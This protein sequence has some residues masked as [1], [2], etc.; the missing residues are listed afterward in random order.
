MYQNPSAY[1]TVLRSN[2]Q[3]LQHIP[4]PTEEMQ[5]VGVAQDGLAI[6]YLPAPSEDVQKTAVC[7]NV[8]ALQYIPTPSED[9]LHLALTSQSHGLSYTQKTSWRYVMNRCR[10]PSDALILAAIAKWTYDDA[11]RGPEWLAAVRPDPSPEIDMAVAVAVGRFRPGASEA[12]TLA[13][14]RRDGMGLRDV[15]TQTPELVRAAVASDASALAHVSDALFSEDVVR[16]ALTAPM[17]S[18][19]SPVAIAASRGVPVTPELQ[20]LW[21]TTS[22]RNIRDFPDADDDLQ[23]FSMDLDSSAYMSIRG[24]CAR[25]TARDEEGYSDY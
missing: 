23:L 18:D 19:A 7:S 5:R 11:V 21:V 10:A 1:F 3:V 4:D 9:V 15:E 16:L 14:L 25:A 12:V 20:R 13:A 17:Y 22:P 8:K 24:P 2:G 6:K